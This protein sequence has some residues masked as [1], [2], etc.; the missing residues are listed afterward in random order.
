MHMI[1]CKYVR[2][3]WEPDFFLPGGRVEGISPERGKCQWKQME[4]L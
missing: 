3:L 1:A 4:I 2:F